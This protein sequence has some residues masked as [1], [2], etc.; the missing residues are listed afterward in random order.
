MSYW[1]NVDPRALLFL[2]R[3]A[4]ASQVRTLEPESTSESFAFIEKQ[5][6]VTP[7]AEFVMTR[8]K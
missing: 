5:R 2:L 4:E 7:V 8:R 1:L 6:L 3:F